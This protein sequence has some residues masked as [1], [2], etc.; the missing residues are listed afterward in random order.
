[1]KYYRDLLFVLIL[2]VLSIIWLITPSLSVY[3]FIIIPYALLTLILPGYSLL[4]A[5]KPFI[6]ETGILGRGVLTVNLSILVTVLVFIA[7][8][9]PP[10]DS[11]FNALAALTIFFALVGFVRRTGQ[12]KEPESS[13]DKEP[14]SEEPEVIHIED[15][16][17]ADLDDE[18]IAIKVE[19]VSMMFNLSPDKVDNLKEYVIKLLKRQLFFQEFWALKDISFTVKK[20]EKLGIMGLNGAGKSTLLKLISGVMK[21]T[22][23]NIT[24]NGGVVPLL[25]LGGGFDSNYTGRENIFLRGALLGYTKE[26]ME[27]KYDEIVEFSE[28]EEFIDVPVKNYS[29][30]MVSRLGFSISTIL[31]PQILILDEVLS[32]GDAKF[33]E[34]SMKRMKS[35]LSKDVTV[36]LV[37]HSASQIKKL[38]SRAIWLEKGKM[39]MM[40]DAEEVADTFMEKVL[41]EHDQ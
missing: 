11:L 41:S 27:D 28:L 32:V 10:L 21:P 30:G 16:P 33:Q 4:A 20:G 35:F 12:S 5:L 29:S 38:C 7:L 39:V 9:N 15:D 23:G 1:M 6:Y 34:K 8:N 13:L 17:W 3:P 40:G 31:H 26:F 22:I 19:N 14:E 36:I 2:D 37:S 24:V 18:E 25:E